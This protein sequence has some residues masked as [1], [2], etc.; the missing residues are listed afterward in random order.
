V[1][2]FQLYGPTVDMS[3]SAVPGTVLGKRPR[4]AEETYNNEGLKVNDC[5]QQC[6]RKK[7]KGKM[8]VNGSLEGARTTNKARHKPVTRTPTAKDSI[9]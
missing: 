7:G 2:P 6:L 5:H 9:P 1:G 3:A 8:A 4:E